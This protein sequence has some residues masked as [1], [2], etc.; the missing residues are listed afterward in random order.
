MTQN[1]IAKWN[2]LHGEANSR[3]K[4]PS[5]SVIRFIRKHFCGSGQYELLDLGCG[6]GRH[7]IYMKE[8][9]IS[10]C[11]ID[12]SETSID[13]VKQ[14]FEARDWRGE[15]HV[16]SLCSLPFDSNRFDGI[17]CYG[18]LLYLKLSDIKIAISE[19]FRVLK[20]GGKAFVVVRSIEDMRYGM[21]LEVENNTFFIDHD[22]T[23]EEGL[24]IHF[25]TPDEVRTLFRS[26][27]DVQLGFMQFAGEQL[28]KY[29]SDLYIL[30]TK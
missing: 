6:S 9:G 25:F 16:G 4:Y 7:M 10:V 3:L 21:G 23:G 1:D 12:Y 29:N 26:F 19:M 14:H 28:N 18:V 13:Y 30:V 20:P 5:E 17:I 8:E 27:S 24:T 22:Q 15:F 2:E 11:G